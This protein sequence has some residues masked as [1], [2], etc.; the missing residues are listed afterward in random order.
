MGVVC[1]VEGNPVRGQTFGHV[2]GWEGLRRVR[3]RGDFW[4]TMDKWAEVTKLHNIC[5]SRHPCQCRS[6]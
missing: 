4:W 5:A 6:D 3:V 1:I 2:G